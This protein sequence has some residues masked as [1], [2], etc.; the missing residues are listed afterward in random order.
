MNVHVT[1]LKG[2][3]L[4]MVSGFIESNAFVL[5]KISMLLFDNVFSFQFLKSIVVSSQFSYQ[6]FRFVY[7]Y[8]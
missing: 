2:T 8:I 7:R 5:L 3:K 1:W 6:Y 4:S